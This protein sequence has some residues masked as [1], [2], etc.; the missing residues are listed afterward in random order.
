MQQRQNWQQ[1]AMGEEVQD[2]EEGQ[3][4]AAGDK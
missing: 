3:S 1:A 2:G 4:W